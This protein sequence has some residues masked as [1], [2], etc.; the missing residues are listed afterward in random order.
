MTSSRTKKGKIL[1][2]QAELVNV[3]AA[4]DAGVLTSAQ[5]LS[6]TGLSR[7]TFLRLVKVWRATGELPAS[8]GN[9]NRMPVNKLDPSL[10][11]RIKELAETKF[12]EMQ[13]TM[14]SRCLKK[15]E[16]I[17][18][19][20]ETARCILHE[21]HPEQTPQERRSAA[22]TLRRRTTC[23]E[24][25]QIDGSPH[26]WFGEDRPPA[27]LIA[28]IDDATG[29]ITGKI[30]AAGFFETESV[31]GYF[32][33]LIRYI[34][35][36]GIPVALYSD[37]H[38]IFKAVGERHEE[39]DT[40]TQY[41]R[42]CKALGIQPIYA[43]SPQAKGRIERLF[44][45]LQGRWPLEFRVRGIT[46]IAEANLHLDEFVEDFNQEFSIPPQNETDSHV[47]VA[48]DEMEEV[49][50]QCGIWEERLISK[51]LTV[52]FKSTIIQIKA[53]PSLRYALIGASVNIVQRLDG[54][55]ELLWRDEK[56][57]K[58]PKLPARYRS[59]D[60]VTSDRKPLPSITEPLA[61]ETSKTID[62]AMDRVMER[63][64]AEPNRFAAFHS[65]EARRALARKQKRERQLEEAKKVA[66]RVT[67][68][69]AKLKK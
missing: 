23:G 52:S 47:R 41:Q 12:A 56:E 67:A 31:E 51:N 33:L 9:L 46:S 45:T 17:I 44:K 54:K 53:P 40:E 14:L 29:K 66:E 50:R 58:D 21:L 61:A 2:N 39:S 49:V 37:R 48:G 38:P 34:S 32:S 25:V 68:A 30:M 8:H 62:A 7:S 3:L 13:P 19:S 59:L 11:A 24:L 16:G 36:H 6:K 18:I 55:V 57:N 42:A 43:Y 20:V 35:R 15:Y 69:K 4:F 27:C 65:A 26:H 60:F 1:L 5:A 63:L 28:F 64:A 10:E 22:H